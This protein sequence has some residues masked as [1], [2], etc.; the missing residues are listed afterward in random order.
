MGEYSSGGR[1]GTAVLVSTGR[2]GGQELQYW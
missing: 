1:A 2:V